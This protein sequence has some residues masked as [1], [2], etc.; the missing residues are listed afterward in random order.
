MTH[1]LS[2]RSE[3]EEISCQA[4]AM[5]LSFSCSQ[6]VVNDSCDAQIDEHFDAS[7]NFM[8]QALE[9]NG[10]VLVQCQKVQTLQ[11]GGGE[12]EGHHNKATLQVPI[13]RKQIFVCVNTRRPGVFFLWKTKDNGLRLAW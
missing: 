13:S 8:N 11:G 3:H 1:V 2:I 5:R 10:K 6:V 9:A 4:P 12:G 7:F